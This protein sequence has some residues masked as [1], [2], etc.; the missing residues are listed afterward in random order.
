MY[1]PI[2]CNYKS[3]ILRKVKGTNAVVGCAEMEAS[4][5]NTPK[6]KKVQFEDVAHC[7]LQ[8]LIQGGFF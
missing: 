1:L 7:L 5:N 6:C 8:K 4:Y 3:S 2:E